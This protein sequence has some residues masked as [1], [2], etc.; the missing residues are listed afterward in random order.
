MTKASPIAKAIK[1]ALLAG[2]STSMLSMPVFAEEVGAE[3]EVERISV[4]GSRL[5]KAEF[6]N[7][8]PIHVITAE[9]AMKAGVRTVADLL[10]N[11]SMANGQ[12]FDGSYNSNSGGSNASEAPP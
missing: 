1:Y 2:V 9:D 5:K 4:T 3:K 12:Q 8:S 6:S 7:A 11:T 10:Q